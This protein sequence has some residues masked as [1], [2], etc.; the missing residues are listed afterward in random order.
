MSIPIGLKL[1][2]IRKALGISQRGL[3]EL[4]GVSQSN[5]AKYEQDKMKPSFEAI[6]R[7]LNE[8]PM[9]TSYIIFDDANAKLPA[10]VE[11][12]NIRLMKKKLN[13]AD[14]LIDKE[15]MT[16]YRNDLHEL[17]NSLK[18]HQPEEP[19]QN[20]RY[21]PIAL[22]TQGIDPEVAQ[23]IE[24]LMLSFIKSLAFISE[25]INESKNGKETP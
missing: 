14:F 24:T 17:V 15:N 12:Q 11:P 18:E 20:S 7:L 5:I 19:S 13:Q 9:L 3:A 8:L 21:I 6:R 1:R 4:M 23:E 16:A 10:Q 25:K 2:R 22:K